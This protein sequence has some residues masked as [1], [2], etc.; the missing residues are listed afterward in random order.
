MATVRSVYAFRHRD[1]V[2]AR[3]S[4]GGAFSAICDVLFQNAAGKV[5]VYGAAFDGNWQVQHQKAQSRAE[6]DRFCGSKYVHSDTS[7]VYRDLVGELARGKTVLFTGTPCQ[8]QAVRRYCAGSG[9]DS[10]RLYLVDVICHGTAKPEI[11]KAYTAW[12]E[13][14]YHSKIAEFQFRYK[15]TRWRSYPAYVRFQNGRQLVNT[16][17]ARLYTELFLSTLIL[18]DC[19]YQCRFANEDRPSDL[20]IGDF[21]GVESVMPA[22]PK[23]NG[24]SEILVNTD[25]GEQLLAGLQA[26]PGVCIAQ[27]RSGAYRKYQHNLHTPTPKSRKLPAF[28]RDMRTK[29]FA[30]VLK[31]Y[32]GDQWRGKLFYAVR[33]TCGESGLTEMAKRLL[34]RGRR[35]EGKTMQNEP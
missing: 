3:S 1:D 18:R 30:T 17:D 23:G 31:I 8:V 16:L 11:W 4:S 5:V 14:K 22:F 34:A 26:L 25:K 32:A 6:C 7:G 24:T 27:C 9:I 15:Q 21:W 10:R 2:L 29:P 28:Q 13:S 19:C 20:T 33:K 12:L 35:T